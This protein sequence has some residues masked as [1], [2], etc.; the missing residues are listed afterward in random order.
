MTATRHPSN[1]NA[2]LQIHTGL[3]AG[4]LKQNHGVAVRTQVRAGGL[5]TNHP[6]QVRA[7]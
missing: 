5:Y 6:V 2:P 4:G 1:H 7:R 3:R